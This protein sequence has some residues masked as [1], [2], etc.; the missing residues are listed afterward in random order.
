MT[1]L[2]GPDGTETSDVSEPASDVAPNAVTAIVT[3][4]LAVIGGLLTL[5]NGI[6]GLSGLSALVT[7]AGLRSLALR[8]PGVLTMTVLATLLSVVCGVLLLAGALALVRRKVI[9]RRLI[10][11]GSALIIVGSLVSLWINVATTGSYA[12]PGSSGLAVLSFALPIVTIVLAVLPTT[13]RWIR[14]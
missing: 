4:V 2:H 3:A 13:A 11:I 5:G 9:G 8:S 10:V 12:A 1:S 6:L 14:T 7:D